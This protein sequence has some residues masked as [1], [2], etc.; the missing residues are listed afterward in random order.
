MSA[1]TNEV[2]LSF[3]SIAKREGFDVRLDKN[4]EEN[5]NAGIKFAKD[6]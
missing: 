4:I 6:V 5:K 2:G 1:P 3:L